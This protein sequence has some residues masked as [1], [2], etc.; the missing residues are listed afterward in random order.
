M[1]LA[2]ITDPGLVAAAIAHGLGI[3]GAARPDP[4]GSLIAY[5]QGKQALLLLDNFEQVAERRPSSPN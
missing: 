5:L 1:N 2:P 3:K 4:G